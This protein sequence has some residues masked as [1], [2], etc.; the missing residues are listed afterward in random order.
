MSNRL[1]KFLHKVSDKVFGLAFGES[2]LHRLFRSGNSKS[3][4]IATFDLIS[5]SQQREVD[6][7]QNIGRVGIV[8]QGPIVEGNT[9]KFCQFIRLT[10]PEA[11]IVLSTWEDEDVSKFIAL[12][13][14][15]FQII[16]SKKPEFP[17]PSNINMQIVSSRAGIEHLEKLGCSHILKTRTDIFLANA[18]FINYLVWAHGKGMAHSI[19]FSSF[20]SFLFR[21]FSVSDQVMFGK[22]ENIAK[23]WKIDLVKD[24]SSFTIPEVYLFSEYIKSFGFQP[25]ENFESYLAALAEYSVIAD[26][27]QLGQTWNKG[28]FTA[29]NYRWRGNN[30]PHPMSPL[31]YWLWDLIGKDISYF[32]ALRKRLT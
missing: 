16:Q 20:N 4:L 12:T 3:D 25:E 26:H 23:F 9:M 19:V 2:L 21:L 27:E 5:V 8:I 29:L 31:S 28:S 6:L 14:E 22:T 18:Q 15:Y 30:F 24:G 1:K 11:N 32:Q 10:Y 7:A 17:G 13:D